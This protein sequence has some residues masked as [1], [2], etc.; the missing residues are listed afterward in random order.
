MNNTEHFKIALLYNMYYSD[1]SSAKVYC[2]Y[3]LYRSDNKYSYKYASAHR[4]VHVYIDMIEE[5]LKLKLL[6]SGK[7]QQLIQNIFKEM[8]LF[9]VACFCLWCF[10]PTTSLPE[11][12]K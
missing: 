1:R 9:Q 5:N 12:D 11:V 10:R 7:L 6:T 4:C 8:M 3:T 2:I